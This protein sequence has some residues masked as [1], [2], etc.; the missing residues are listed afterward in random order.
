MTM[1][2]AFYLLFAIAVFGTP[3]LPEALPLIWFSF[4]VVGICMGIYVV[5]GA[6][7]LVP[8]VASL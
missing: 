7:G 5:L 1:D 8:V 2:D 6:A 4:S 3:L